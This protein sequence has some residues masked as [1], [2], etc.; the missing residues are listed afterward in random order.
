MA[1]VYRGPKTRQHLTPLRSSCIKPGCLCGLPAALVVVGKA[2]GFCHKARR[3]EHDARH[4]V[5][6]ARQIGWPHRH[7]LGYV[8]QLGGINR[9]TQRGRHISPSASCACG[10]LNHINH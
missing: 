6:T 1:V 3:F 4:M 2:D 10:A 8:W 7:F 5:F 9:H